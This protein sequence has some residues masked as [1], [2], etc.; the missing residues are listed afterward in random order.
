[1]RHAL[2]FPDLLR[3]SSRDVKLP[4]TTLY[5]A[6]MVDDDTTFQLR[7]DRYG[8]ELL[9]GL[10]GAYGDRAGE[11]FERLTE[12]L[13]GAFD[14]RPA[15]L[16][17][18]DEARLL[19]PDWLQRPDQIGYVCYADRFARSLPKVADHIDHLEMEVDDEIWPLPKYRE[20]L[21]SK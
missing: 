1:M 13:R 2:P 18:L 21:F 7:M 9:S 19:S 8:P 12:A 11:L 5:A 4:A 15:D 16:R 20:L 17:V 10:E 6:A 3:E 14:A